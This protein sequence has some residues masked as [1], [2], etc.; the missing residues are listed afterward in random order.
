MDAVR[1]HTLRLSHVKTLNPY[2]GQGS[3]SK[4]NLTDHGNQHKRRL[5]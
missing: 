3:Q 1:L 4:D 5:T 2:S